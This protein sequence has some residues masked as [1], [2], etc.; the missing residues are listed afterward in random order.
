MRD[1]FTSLYGIFPCKECI[2]SGI[3]IEG[4][5][6]RNTVLDRIEAAGIEYV[7]PRIYSR[8]VFANFPA[9]RDTAYRN[10]DT[11]HTPPYRHVRTHTP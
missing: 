7:I 9:D 11:D 8:I 4:G 6:G 1:L 10:I 5:L 3:Q 2:R